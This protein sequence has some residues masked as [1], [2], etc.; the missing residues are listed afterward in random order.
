MAYYETAKLT[1]NEKFAL[2]IVVIASF[3][4]LLKDKE[5]Y[6]LIWERIKKQLERDK[7]IHENTMHYWALSG[8]KLENCFAVTPC[9]RE[10]CRCHLS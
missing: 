5:K 8:E 3:N 4:D 7:G 6:L 1:I 2:M 9:I 10:V